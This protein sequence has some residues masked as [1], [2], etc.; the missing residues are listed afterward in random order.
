M[1]LRSWLGMTLALLPASGSAAEPRQACETVAPPTKPFTVCFEDAT[2]IK[3]FVYGF[4]RT[5][6]AKDYL[7]SPPD[8]GLPS[9]GDA[10]AATCE[11]DDRSVTVRLAP[12]SASHRTVPGTPSVD[13]E[14]PGAL[15]WRFRKVDP[16]TLET[17]WAWPRRIHSD[18]FPCK[19]PFDAYAWTEGAPG[20]VH[21]RKAIYDG[22]VRGGMLVLKV[23]PYRKLHDRVTKV[24]APKDCAAINEGRRIRF[25]GTEP[26]D[27]VDGVRRVDVVQDVPSDP[28]RLVKS[29]REMM[30]DAASLA[31]RPLRVGDLHEHL[32]ILRIVLA[33]QATGAKGIPEAE[34]R[35]ARSKRVLDDFEKGLGEGRGLPF[36]NWNYALPQ[37]LMPSSWS[38]PVGPEAMRT[39]VAV[40][41]M[42]D[43]SGLE[44]EL[45][46]PEGRREA[47]R[48]RR[49]A[50][51]VDAAATETA[52]IELHPRVRH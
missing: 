35:V 50:R 34:D 14:D 33:A 24:S 44:R 52:E 38:W 8:S 27:L 3:W 20:S 41:L 51:S 17:D 36:R 29:N 46:T 4:G 26:H 25:V 23:D 47:E 16:C 13:W 48:V 11:E 2:R 10:R 15:V 28:A 49:L 6:V 45:P 9:S 32:R 30:E 37:D 42:K 12:L 7:P 19:A 40:R 22:T 1:S 39:S 18:A 21:M 43:A 5:S 31:R